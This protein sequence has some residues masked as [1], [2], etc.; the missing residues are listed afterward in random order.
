MIFYRI[1][2]LPLEPEQ[3]LLLIDDKL[4]LK[5]LLLL[6]TLVPDDMGLKKLID[7]SIVFLKTIENHGRIH[8]QRLL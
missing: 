2:G 4:I 5:L 8:M 7:L 6:L 1:E 3:N